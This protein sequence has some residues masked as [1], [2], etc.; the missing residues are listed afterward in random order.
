VA[1]ST[2]GHEVELASEATY[3]SALP[4][5]R[6]VVLA[7]AAIMGGAIGGLLGLASARLLGRRGPAL[8]RAPW[9]VGPATQRT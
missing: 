3:A 7:I 8:T 4:R 6:V 2:A 5:Q 1:N 9:R